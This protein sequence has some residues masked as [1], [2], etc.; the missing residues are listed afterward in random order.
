MIR[1]RQNLAPARRAAALAALL[2][3]ALPAAPLRA[4][5]VTIAGASPVASADPHISNTAS[6]SALGLH[7]FDR[8]VLQDAAGNLRPGLATQW[9]A[10]SDRVWEFRLRP[11]VKWHDGR[12]FTADDVVFTFD[13]LPNA[14]GGFVSA[15]RPIARVE[16][17]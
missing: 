10:V 3:L 7:V 17:R 8:L 6:N 16:T 13:R 9:R 2:A 5:S 15:V 12:D 4:Q 14:Q 1:A 11:G